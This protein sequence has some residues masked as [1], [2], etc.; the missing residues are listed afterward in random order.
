MNERNIIQT[1]IF[2]SFLFLYSFLAFN[3]FSVFAF[4]FTCLFSILHSLL[5]SFFFPSLFHSFPLSFLF[6][7]FPFWFFNLW[8]HFLIHLI[9]CVLAC[10]SKT[11]GTKLPQIICCRFLARRTIFWKHHRL[12]SLSKVVKILEQ[13]MEKFKNM[14]RN[15]LHL[16]SMQMTRVSMKGVL[17]KGVWNLHTKVLSDAY[18]VNAKCGKKQDVW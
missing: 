12:L 8:I 17:Q 13:P 14:T 6:S 5:L 7:S 16:L 1:L 15:N 4:S 18:V 2:F 9:K 3:I 11:N 10:N